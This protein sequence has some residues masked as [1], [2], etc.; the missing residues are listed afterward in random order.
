MR[1]LLDDWAPSSLLLV[2]TSTLPVVL[3][4]IVMSDARAALRM[5][6]VI[7]V[8]MLFV[9]GCSLAHYAGLRPWAMGLGMAT[10][11]AAL[12]GLTIALGG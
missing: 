9:G 4:F 10:L 6:N 3:P 1:R 7:S 8:A 5:S 2:F 12:V 11:G